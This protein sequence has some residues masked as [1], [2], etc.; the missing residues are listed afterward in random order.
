MNV[1]IECGLISKTVG[2]GMGDLGRGP[3]YILLGDGILV[4]VICAL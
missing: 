4:E 3:T 2:S 1:F